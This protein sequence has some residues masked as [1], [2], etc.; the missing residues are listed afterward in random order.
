MESNELLCAIVKTDK[1]ELTEMLLKSGADVNYVDQQKMFPL[2]HAYTAKMI[3]Q[4]KIL[5]ANGANIN[6]IYEGNTLLNIE[7]QKAIS[8]P[9]MIKLFIDN[10]ADPNPMHSNP[11]SCVVLS[12]FLEKNDIVCATMLLSHPRIDINL[13]TESGVS[14]LRF[15]C[16]YKSNSLGILL[17]NKGADPNIQGNDGCT[18]LMRCVQEKNIGMASLLISHPDIKLNLQEKHGNTALHIAC[19]RDESVCIYQLLSNGADQSI[20]NESGEIAFE[21]CATE[22]SKLIFQIYQQTKNI[23][24]ITQETPR[25]CLPNKPNEKIKCGSI[26]QT[27]RKWNKIFNCWGPF[28]KIP[29]GSNIKCEYINSKIP[30]HIIGDYD[31]DVRIQFSSISKEDGS[32]ITGLYE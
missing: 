17:L 20:K 16:V 15:A 4:M 32:I 2:Y 10:D 3:A 24:V 6:Q 30:Y 18:A 28:K 25:F 7:A 13:Q 12:K 11:T 23:P 14:P 26:G 29:K 22:E 19:S 5:L 27:Y 8:D 31:K 9:Q 1:C 21:R